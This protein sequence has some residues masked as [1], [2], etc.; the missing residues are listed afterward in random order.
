MDVAGRTAD[1]SNLGRV[2]VG[3]AALCE[4]YAAV[5]HEGR[6]PWFLFQALFPMGG[7]A[8]VGRVMVV[9]ACLS[10]ISLVKPKGAVG[11]IMR[12]CAR[13]WGF[14]IFCASQSCWTRYLLDG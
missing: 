9:R 2:I 4:R 5:L 10:E 7:M 3:I 14:E 6:V 13:Y 12:L 1:V 11:V 8:E